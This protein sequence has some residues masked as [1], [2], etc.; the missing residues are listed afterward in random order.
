[1]GQYSVYRI[2]GMHTLGPFLIQN[3]VRCATLKQPSEIL[4]GSRPVIKAVPIWFSTMGFAHSPVLFGDHL[5]IGRINQL[6]D[7]FQPLREVL[8]LD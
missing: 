5:E 7:F 6:V 3:R 1:M 8:N 4:N 2:H